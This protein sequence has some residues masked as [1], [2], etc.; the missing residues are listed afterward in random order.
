MAKTSRKR[1]S[2]QEQISEE[3]KLRIVCLFFIFLLIIAALQLGFIGEHLDYIFSYLF[4][5]LNGIVYLLLIGVF[6]Y[7]VFKASYPKLNGPKA[8]GVY[9]LLVGVTIFISATPTIKG[10]KVI[11]SY[12]S[13]IPL[14]RG[15]FI[16]AL[17]YGCLSALFDYVGSIIAAVFI[18]IVGIILLGS[19][20]Y[21]EHKKEIQKKAKMIL[22]RQKHH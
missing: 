18:I 19:K 2:K 6:G 17:L 9:F 7:I 1:K 13:Q 22:I 14:N 8:V 16:G 10:M 11:Q 3:L 20:F 12:I 5:N 21:F 15:G 4:G